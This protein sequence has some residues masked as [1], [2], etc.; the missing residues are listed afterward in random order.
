MSNAS[1]SS[2]RW[3]TEDAES[4]LLKTPKRPL[5]RSGT[6]LSPGREEGTSVW[7][8]RFSLPT[9]LPLEQGLSE[10]LPASFKLSEGVGWGSW[11][12]SA[13]SLPQNSSRISISF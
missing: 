9:L 13:P 4:F 1:A 2:N 12:L 3:P 11:V 8:V 10:K 7:S 5:G 6:P